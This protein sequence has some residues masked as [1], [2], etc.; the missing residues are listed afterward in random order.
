MCK[1]SL[2]PIEIY[3]NY[4]KGFFSVNLHLQNNKF[5]KVQAKQC[6]G[7]ILKFLKQTRT[8]LSLLLKGNVRNV[9]LRNIASY[10]AKKTF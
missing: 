10:A 9:I 7:R 5:R 3:R 2:A 6:T 1:T 8:R 4:P